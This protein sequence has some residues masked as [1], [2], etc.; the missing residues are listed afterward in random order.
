[1]A[2]PYY[3]GLVRIPPS[4]RSILKRRLAKWAILILSIIGGFSALAIWLPS[5]EHALDCQLSA[6][7]GGASSPRHDCTQTAQ[8]I[9]AA[10]SPQTKLIVNQRITKEIPKRVV[11]VRSSTVTSVI[12]MPSPKRH[13]SQPPTQPMASPTP[14]TPPVDFSSIASNPLMASSQE[15]VSVA[16]LIDA[17]PVTS[18][19]PAHTNLDILLAEQGDAFAQYRLGRFYAQQNGSL[20]AESLSWYMNASD[21]LQRLASSGNGNAMY[22]LGVMF[23]FGR[24]VAENKDE[25]RKWLTQAV[26]YQIPEAG[27]VLAKLNEDHPADP[28]S[29]RIV[30]VK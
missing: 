17:P 28:S 11:P 10:P 2:T 24:G 13:I 19:T 15:D 7:A 21:G 18:H 6:D 8:P 23:A 4:D 22:I 25:A 27:Q 29:P 16:S 12:A 26:A 3:P 9:A 5:S 1:M 30:P 14:T 20:S